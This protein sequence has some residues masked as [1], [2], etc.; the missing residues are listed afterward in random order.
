M[1]P[2]V[3]DFIWMKLNSKDHPAFFKYWQV[4]LVPEIV[5]LDGR[6]RDRL[7][8]K[9]SVAPRAI[10]DQLVQI[11]RE[12]ALVLTLPDGS[13]L[14]KSNRFA[15]VEA[16][17]P[18]RYKGHFYYEPF[19]TFRR[20]GAIESPLIVP[21]TQAESR[22]ET[23]KGH[24]DSGALVISAGSK[25]TAEFRI[26]ISDR[27]N[28]VD[29]VTG[30][31]LVEIF[32][33][34]GSGFGREPKRVGHVAI[35]PLGERPDALGVPT[36]PILLGGTRGRLW[37]ERS[38]VT[39]PFNFRTHKAYL[40][41]KASGHGTSF[42]VD[43]LRVDLLPVDERVERVTLERETDRLKIVRAPEPTDTETALENL[44]GEQKRVFEENFDSYYMKRFNQIS[45]LRTISV[46]FSRL[47]LSAGSSRTAY[48]RVD[49]GN[50]REGALLYMDVSKDIVVDD[51]D[52]GKI[53]LTMALRAVNAFESTPTRIAALSVVP[54]AEPPDSPIAD[55]YYLSLSKRDMGV[56]TQRTIE[57]KTFD[58]RT[59]KVYLMLGSSVHGLAF[60]VDDI[61]ANLIFVEPWD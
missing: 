19:D 31:L 11:P 28:L 2:A 12:D 10:L 4:H 21:V 42:M 61:S 56:W 35:V 16:Y 59:H 46:G 51:W 6:M 8:L 5:V 55:L 3:R 43:D 47:M 33:K 25:S 45:S 58:L 50:K 29:Q 44:V 24:H 40:F 20:V 23:E 37:V 48:L 14:A 27:L 7:R 32:M 17:Q 53:R 39:E 57:T 18:G 54:A 41:L 1:Q 30:R 60:F 52:Q 22:I 13:S 34:R 36:F 9:G 38:V 26:D 49:A 15:H